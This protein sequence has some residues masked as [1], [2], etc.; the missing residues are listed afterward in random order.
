MYQDKR[1]SGNWTTL[2]EGVSKRTFIHP[3]LPG[4]LIKIPRK[5]WGFREK[6]GEEDLILHYTNLEQIRRI[7]ASFDRIALPE[8]NLYKTSKGLMVVEQQFDLVNYC[9]VTNGPDKQEMML[10]FYVFA[11]A[12]DLCDLDPTSTKNAGI[13]S[14]TGHLKMGIFDVDCRNHQ[15]DAEP[16]WQDPIWWGGHPMNLVGALLLPVGTSVLGG[17][18]ALAKKIAELQP[19]TLLQIGVGA[20]AAA[21]TVYEQPA[22]PQPAIAMAAAAAAMAVTSVATMTAAKVYSWVLAR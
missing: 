5:E 6:T 7:A 9:S 1:P 18:A 4:M 16:T 11:E 2:G 3:D 21:F 20:V 14:Q 15:V 17:I 22:P 19:I 10:Q 13:L 8:S 12:A